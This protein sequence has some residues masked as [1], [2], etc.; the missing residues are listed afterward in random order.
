[1]EVMLIVIV[2]IGTTVFFHLR[3]SKRDRRRL[4]DGVG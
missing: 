3:A 1:M 2:F 4:T